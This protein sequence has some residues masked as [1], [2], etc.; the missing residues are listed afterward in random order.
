MPQAEIVMRRS[1]YRFAPA[2]V[3][4][5]GATVGML[6]TFGTASPQVAKPGVDCTKASLATERMI[7]ANANLSALDREMARVFHEQVAGLAADERKALT[8]D[9]RHWLRFRAQLCSLPQSAKVRVARLKAVV[10]CIAELYR[11][12]IRV[13]KGRCEIDEYHTVD[14]MAA[15]EKP[16]S[17][18]VPKGFKVDGGRRIFVISEEAW[19]TQSY[20]LP[21]QDLPAARVAGANLKAPYR[22]MALCRVTGPDGKRWLV[23]QMRDGT[24]DYVLESATRPASE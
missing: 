8:G 19:I 2:I 6:P 9:Q 18:R 12:R 14:D 1:G 16:W 11:E 21:S 23:S 20:N 3:L 5:L 10:P 15:Q 13:L 22:A 4:S 7:C 24:L 17:T